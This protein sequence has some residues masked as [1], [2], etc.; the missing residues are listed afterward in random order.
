[1]LIWKLSLPSSK[2]CKN[3]TLLIHIILEK[4]TLVNTVINESD[5]TF[6]NHQDLVLLMMNISKKFNIKLT[7]DQEKN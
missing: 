6:R 1:M 7:K 4:G 2:D 5:N 3:F